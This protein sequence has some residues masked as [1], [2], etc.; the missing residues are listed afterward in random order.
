MNKKILSIKD[1]CRILVESILDND[2]LN[3]NDT[4][5]KLVNEMQEQ[6]EDSI[7]KSLIA[8]QDE[9][10][11]ED[12]EENSSNDIA[13]DED[14]DTSDL[15][16]DDSELEDNVNNDSEE[17]IDE[18]DEN[19][20]GDGKLNEMSIEMANLNHSL[21]KA[22]I[23]KLYNKIST[24]KTQLNALNLD[25]DEMEYIELDTKLS[26]YSEVLETLQQ[27]SMPGIDGTEQSEI[28]D[29]INI[30]FKAL[31]TLESE[32]NANTTEDDNINTSNEDNNDLNNFEEHKKESDNKDEDED[33]K[34]N[35]SDS[36]ESDELKEEPDENKDEEIDNSDSEDEDEDE[37]IE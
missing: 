20:V 28:T 9:E 27:Q 29:K 32:I 26:F 34:S 13:E 37:D 4:L 16:T 6:R 33:E 2:L 30:V 15:N 18:D 36:D 12:K 8:E 23:K 25:T 19:I 11:N 7:I 5:H 22:K 31:K 3:A 24:L 35:N 10:E 1:Q 21:N 17:S 14:T